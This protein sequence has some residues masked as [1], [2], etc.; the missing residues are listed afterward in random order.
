ILKVFGHRHVVPVHEAAGVDLAQELGKPDL[1]LCPGAVEGLSIVLQFSV[2]HFPQ[3]NANPVFVWPS[4]LDVP[5]WPCFGHRLSLHYTMRRRISRTSP[6]M[7]QFSGDTDIGMYAG[8]ALISTRR[9]PARYTCLITTPS[10]KMSTTAIC[11][12]STKGWRLTR[13]RSPG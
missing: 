3:K 11:P 7:R 1:R 10:S 9:F 5:S 8:F 12:F 13:T 2:G 6:M 4:G